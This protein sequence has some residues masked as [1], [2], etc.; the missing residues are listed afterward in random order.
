MFR[1]TKLPIEYQPLFIRKYI[2]R[3]ERGNCTIYILPRCFPEFVCFRKVKVRRCT[4]SPKLINVP[5][6]SVL[7]A[8]AYVSLFHRSTLLS[9][10]VP[11]ARPT[12]PVWP[13]HAAGSL[14]LSRVSMTTAEILLPSKQYQRL[15]RTGRGARRR[16]KKSDSTRAPGI[17]KRSQNSIGYRFYFTPVVAI[18]YVCIYLI[19]TIASDS[20]T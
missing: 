1:H 4:A 15:P 17:N 3:R 2:R 18:D 11:S 7:R 8:F 10:N 12:T 19:A 9:F 5:Y 14:G 6:I 13:E 16:P 20:T